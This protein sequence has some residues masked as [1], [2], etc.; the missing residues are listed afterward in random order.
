[1]FWIN[2]NELLHLLWSSAIISF[3]LACTY[4]TIPPILFSEMPNFVF[5]ALS[6]ARAYCRTNL[7]GMRQLTI[8]DN[9]TSSKMRTNR[10]WRHFVTMPT[11]VQG[12]YYQFQTVMPTICNVDITFTYRQT[13]PSRM[14]LGWLTF[15]FLKLNERDD[16][17]TRRMGNALRL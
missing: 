11:T 6:H 15:V 10:R 14:L 7:N 17:P 2:W 1:V 3:I 12:N 5:F 13:F 9:V 16:R 4:A 8:C